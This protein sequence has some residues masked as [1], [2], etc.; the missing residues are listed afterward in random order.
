MTVQAGTYRLGP[1]HGTL[2]VR[3]GRAG[4]AARAG[5]DLTIEATGWAGTATVDPAD[6]A[7]SAVAVEVAVDS[8]E[9]RDGAGG[10]K[11]L[12]DSD[13]AEIRRTLRGKILRTADHPTI[14]FRSSRV[15]GTPEAFTVTGDLTIMGRTQPVTLQGAVTADGRVRGGATVTQTRW[16]ITPYSALFGTLK[17]ADDVRV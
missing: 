17:L 12:T 2:L 14:A 13:R 10:V 9:V 3:T 1:E 5:H 8:L 7:R 15:E 11:P 6:P 16:G 4:L